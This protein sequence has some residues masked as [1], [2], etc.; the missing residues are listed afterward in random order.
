VHDVQRLLFFAP[1]LYAGYVYRV[2]GAV[3]VT[4]AAYIVFL[5]RALTISPYPDP[6]LRASLFAVVG[7]VV[8]VLTGMVRDQS[9]RRSQLEALLKAER[10]R[11]FGMLEMMKEDIYLVDPGYRIR[12]LN[13]SM[14]DQFGHG[15]G[16]F[17]YQY[18]RGLDEPCG[19]VCKL[20]EV[21]RGSTQTWEYT[22][23]DGRTYE[24]ISSPFVDF[25]GTTCQICVFRD[26]TERK[27]VEDELIELNRLKSE[28]VSNVSHE[29][30]SPLTS[31]KGIVSSLLQKEVEGWCMETGEEAAQYRRCD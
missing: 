5:P 30:R 20:E 28:L 8:G 2:R 27:K 15:V 22:F 9:E 24:V 17:C 3:V 26:I 11:I 10:D 31:I 4:L 14:T 21:I 29:L 19:E 23:P 16:S 7:G 12:F 13:K 25:D 1:I 6:L 18:L